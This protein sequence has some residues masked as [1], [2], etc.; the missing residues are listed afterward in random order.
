[1]TF[2]MIMP[3][4]PSQPAMQKKPNW[5]PVSHNPNTMP[6]SESG[7]ISRMISGWRKLP[8]RATRMTTRRMKAS[9]KYFVSAAIASFWSLYCE[10][11]KKV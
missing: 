9:G 2:L 1:M 5:K 3:S 8:N 11:Q 6:M 4:R 10:S 7:R